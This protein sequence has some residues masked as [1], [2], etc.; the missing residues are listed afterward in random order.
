MEQIARNVS[1][2]GGFLAS[3][4]YLIHDRDPLYTDKFDNILKAAG[5]E[6]VKLPP[7]Q[8]ES[9]RPRGTVRQV[10]QRGLSRSSHPHLR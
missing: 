8:S 2:E 3:K 1:S 4:K 5:V 10:R 6:C 7:A 9:E